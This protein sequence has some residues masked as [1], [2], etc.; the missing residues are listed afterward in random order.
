LYR[1]QWRIE[2]PRK[3]LDRDIDD[4]RIQGRHEAAEDE[5]RG[6]P[7]KSGV[8]LVAG[9]IGWRTAVNTSISVCTCHRR[10]FAI[11]F[12]RP[13]QWFKKLEPEASQSCGGRPA[14][15]INLRV[16]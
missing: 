10:R 8:K 4:R 16:S 11:G 15:A 1:R 13:F 7:Q 3:V 9:V 5:D 6:D 12:V 14:R 2:I